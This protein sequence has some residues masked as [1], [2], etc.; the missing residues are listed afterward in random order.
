MKIRRGVAT[1][2]SETSF[3]DL[4]SPDSQEARNSFFDGLDMIFVALLLTGG[5]YFMVSWLQS[6]T[7]LKNFI[8][9]FCNYGLRISTSIPS[10]IFI[11]TIV[12]IGVACVAILIWNFRALP[13]KNDEDLDSPLPEKATRHTALW[14]HRPFTAIMAI[15]NWLFIVAPI[16]GALAFL[17]YLSVGYNRWVEPLQN[18]IEGTRI[19]AGV[20]VAAILVVVAIVIIVSVSENDTRTSEEKQKVHR[21]RLI[22]GAVI[23]GAIGAWNESRNPP[24]ERNYV[25]GA[26]GG[27]VAGAATVAL[28]EALLPILL[29]VGLV[30]GAGYAGALLGYHVLGWPI[31]YIIVALVVAVQ[32]ILTCLG[33]GLLLNFVR[34]LLRGF[35]LF[36]LLIFTKSLDK[37]LSIS[38]TD[39]VGLKDWV[40]LVKQ[41]GQLKLAWRK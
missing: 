18:I 20:I 25:A 14:S 30:A 10:S 40:R 1:D 5:A 6:K 28:V 21:E 15:P 12:F 22:S 36:S 13:E 17:G 4:N 38:R 39:W 27:A 35:C 11:S 37:P 24:A 34:A 19:V 32:V 23:G 16:V 33:V 2:G 9:N 3:I 31:A 29:V 41:N 8:L 26:A 7:L